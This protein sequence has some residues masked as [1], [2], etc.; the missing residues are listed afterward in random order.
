MSVAANLRRCSLFP[1]PLVIHIQWSQHSEPGERL[2]G[3]CE[4]PLDFILTA[5]YTALRACVRTPLSLALVDDD[6]DLS[7]RAVRRKMEAVVDK[8]LDVPAYFAH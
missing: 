8:F 2:C 6:D 5:R 4:R 3:T 7:P 1:G